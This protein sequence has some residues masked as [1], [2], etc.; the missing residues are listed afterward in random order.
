MKTLALLVVLLAPAL[1]TAA[2]LDRVVRDQLAPQLPAGLGI[3]EIHLPRTLARVDVEAASVVVEL[4]REPR[5]GRSSVRVTVPGRAVTF[6]PVSFEALATVAVARRPI[7]Q[8]A[9]IVLD[10][11]DFV[12]RPVAASLDATLVIGARASHAITTGA[13]LGPRDVVLPPPVPRGT[14]VTV[15]L[16]ARGVSVRGTGVLELAARVG[17]PATVRV[18][19]TK[20]VVHGTLTSASTV[21]V[22]GTP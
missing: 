13:V 14:Q 9:T 21:L 5:A 8:G 7:I 3:R 20:Q 19:A 4:P 15:E 10:D 11:V 2:P 22:G 16:R 12:E 6:V 17:L 18:L 1:A